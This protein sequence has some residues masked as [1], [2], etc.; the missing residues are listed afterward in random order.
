MANYTSKNTSVNT[1]Q[2]PAIYR[3]IDWTALYHNW[4]KHHDNTKDIFYIVDWG[5]GKETSHI[6]KYIY[7]RLPKDK[8]KYLGYD[9]YWKTQSENDSIDSII[10]CAFRNRVDIGCFICSNVLNVIKQDKTVIDLKYMFQFYH[11]YLNTPYFITVYEG[12]R[13]CVGK[14]TKPDCWQ[15]NQPLHFYCNLTVNG[16]FDKETIKNKV[17]VPKEFQDVIHKTSTGS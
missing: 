5:C 14:E 10:G 17:I 15:R 16:V 12:D 9:P 3:K 4:C 13:S 2:L 7:E 11:K 6:E 1:K 8:A